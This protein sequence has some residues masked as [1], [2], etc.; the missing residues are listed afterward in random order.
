MSKLPRISIITPS[1]NQ[2]EFIEQTI[3]SVLSQNYPNLEYIVIDGGSTDRSVD[4]IKKYASHF[5]YWISEKDNGQSH[6]I[7]KGLARVTGDVVNWLNSDDYYEPGSLKTIGERFMQDSVNVVCA[8]G[9]VVGDG[10]H[11]KVSPGTDVYSGNL[12]KTLGWARID[13]PETFFRKK[14]YDSLGFVNEKYHY[15]MDK[16]FWV[17]YLLHYG[18]DGILKIDDIVVNFR[19]HANSKTQS[20]TS[21]FHVETLQLYHNLARTFRQ[22]KEEAVLGNL[23]QEKERVEK[24]SV[25]P[26]AEMKLAKRSLQYFLLLKADELYYY[27]DTSTALILLRAIDQELL[28]EEDRSLLRKLKFRSAYVPGFLIRLLRR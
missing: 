8:R 22:E 27:N 20:Q 26:F 13:Q 11:I 12:P 24:G 23:L 1:Y 7:N 28:E 16:E 21:R 18:L 17:R 15:V 2:A 10:N 25:F 19:Y 3:E 9:N 5:A 4:I 6:A 14:V